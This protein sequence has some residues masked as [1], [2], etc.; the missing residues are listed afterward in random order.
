MEQGL[1]DD[2]TV[3]TALAQAEQAPSIHNTQPW[4]WRV[5]DR[6]VHL[7]LDPSRAL[8]ATDPDQRDLV[9]SC[10]AALHHLCV[11]FAALEWSAVVHRL[12]NPD[13]P[14]HLAAVELVP[15]R[16]IP[17]DI[18]LASAISRRRSDR[19]RYSSWPIPAGYL[20]LVTERAG[21]LGATIKLVSDGSRDRLTDAIR[22][23]AAWHAADPEY[24]S[25][26]AIWTGR[27][28]STEGVPARSA[29]QPRPVDELPA[30]AFAAASLADP[31][32]E[33]DHAELLV[34]G[35]SGD[36]RLSRL[37]AGEALSSVLLTATNV[38]L[39]TCPLTEPLEIPKLRRDVRVGVL[40]NVAYPQVVIRIGWAPTS[41][42]PLPATPR[43]SVDETV[44]PLQ[45]PVS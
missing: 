33:P 13:D 23:A 12:P 35:T 10:G 36:D 6:S 29:P 22:K 11:A 41:D 45:T 38:G 2:R 8:I 18:A 16:S 44:E 4:R 25:E 7:D 24:L 5:G 43:R 9:I 42:A 37:R 27:H 39:A 19:R 17:L 30:R 31:A 1:P 20:G 40:N 21:A 26:L 3:A 14:A 32:Y 15:H 34:V 28:G